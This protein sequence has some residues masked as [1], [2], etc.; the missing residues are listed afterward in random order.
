V[1]SCRGF[2][3]A[4]ILK[5][6]YQSGK[7]TLN[8]AATRRTSVKIELEQLTA[9]AA[10]WGADD[11]VGSASHR[12]TRRRCQDFA[13]FPAGA[14]MKAILR[15]IAALYLLCASNLAFA[16]NLPAGFS[17]GYD[18]AWF[19]DHYP[20]WLA[21]NPVYNLLFQTS[22]FSSQFSA[23]VIDAYFAGMKN[24]HAK[25]V[26]IWVFPGLQGIEL[27][28]PPTPGLPQTVG[29][30]S[31]FC[32]NL[33]TV[34][35][36][37]KNH[38][39]Q[40]QVTALN[41]VDM[42]TA[43][44]P[45]SPLRPLKPYFKNLLLNNSGERDAFKKYALG[46]QGQPQPGLLDC[47][48]QFNAAYPNSNVIYGLDL[49]NEIEAAINAGYVDWAGAQDFIRDMAAYV[50]SKSSLRV[51]S[52]AGFGFA[53]FEIAAGLFSGV[54]LDFYDLHAYADWGL[55]P[56]ILVCNRVSADG[57]FIILGEYGQ[58]SQ[59]TDDNLQF[60]TTANFLSTAKATC[61]S[62][63]LAWMYE[64]NVI[65][66]RVYYLTYL[67]PDGTFRPAYNVIQYFGT[68]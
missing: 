55:Y 18:E 2:G 65:P 57:V 28:L 1:R 59:T 62:A 14:K 42:Q 13:I 9:P 26:R 52:S 48:N 33:K 41:G 20:N 63:A 66:N 38:G 47:M 34:F 3:I 39:L 16:G 56:L 36:S 30:T 35:L 27:N 64:I 51:T 54:G 8:K 31:D 40:V 17:V 6:G 49:I 12:L 68:H 45:T 21:S 32:G 10:R 58:T 11:A 5:K 60:W 29:L 7:V 23:N 46:G 19:A 61:F 44:D 53:A 4:K 37:A 15:R 67:R 25:I 22:V 24:G 43:V 50:K